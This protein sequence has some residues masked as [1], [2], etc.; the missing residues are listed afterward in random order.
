LASAIKGNPTCDDP[1]GANGDPGG[2]KGFHGVGK[3]DKMIR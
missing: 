1:A 3:C 2:R